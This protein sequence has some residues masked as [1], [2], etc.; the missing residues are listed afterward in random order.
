MLSYFTE[1]IR[2]F[3][4]RA[5]DM[6]SGKCLVTADLELARALL[7]ANKE[8][9]CVAVRG[10]EILTSTEKGIKP[11]LRWL[12]EGQDLCGFSVA[13][14][15]VGKAPALLYS[16]LGPDAVF[17]PV[18]SHT[19]R[20]VLVAAGIAVSYDE[21][22]HLISNRAGTGQCPMDASVTNVFDPTEAVGVIRDR[23]HQL[24]VA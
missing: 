11:L 7:V 1:Q 14:K 18:M 20:A 6:D 4:G 9:T 10:D 12:A 24:A 19:A 17:A 5:V 8:A 22:T 16:L 2:P 3:V 23:L 13:D 15:V 21:L